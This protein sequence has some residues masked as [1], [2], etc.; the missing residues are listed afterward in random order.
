MDEIA[1]VLMAYGTPDKLEDLHDYLKGIMHGKEPSAELVKKTG[2]KYEKIGFSPLKDMTL[3]Q[4]IL[5]EEELYKEGVKA[6]VKVG[7][8]HWNPTINEALNQIDLKSVSKV[9][10]I[11]A[12]PFYSIAG[13]EEYKVI[14]K[15]YCKDKGI[16][17]DSWYEN[18]DLY[19]AW[20]EKADQKIK[21]FNGEEFYTIFS[22]HGLPQQINDE[23]YKK[24]LLDFTDKLASILNIKEYSLAYQNGDHSD[25]YKPDV[26]D[27]I[28]RMKKNILLIPIG[29]ISESLETL[30]DIDIEYAGLAYK[31]GINFKRVSCIG[32][33]YLTIKTMASAI[34][35]EINLNK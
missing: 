2:E 17:I 8:K 35:N 3:K 10:G 31:L 14:F 27:E 4:A 25:W 24:E 28:N 5:L 13:S 23:R 9:I 29:Y 32:D 18:E 7:M 15:N 34:I 12:H 30:Y 21:E 33:S 22:S 11:V 1:V 26:K 20:K 6:K 16:F 19:K